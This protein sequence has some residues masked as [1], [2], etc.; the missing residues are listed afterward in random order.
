LLEVRARIGD[1]AEDFVHVAAGDEEEGEDDDDDYQDE[2]DE[3]EEGFG[4]CLLD[5]LLL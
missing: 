2:E 5:Y 4:A 3:E 1:G